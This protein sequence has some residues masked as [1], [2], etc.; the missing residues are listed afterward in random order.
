M[1]RFPDVRRAGDF[2]LV[3]GTTARRADG[4]IAGDG[5]I[6]EQTRAA[7]DDIG[8]SLEAAGASLADL[9]DL[10]AFLV[11]MSDF[12]EYDRVYGEYFGEN[13]PARTT[14]AVHQLPHPLLLVEIKATAYVPQVR[15]KT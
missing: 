6:A 2:L 3:S 12:G 13:G 5:D 14:V 11:S 10:N 7:I 9:I 4:T 8:E 15:R 1:S